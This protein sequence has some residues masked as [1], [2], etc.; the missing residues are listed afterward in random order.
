MEL[1]VPFREFTRFDHPASATIG[2]NRAAFSSRPKAD[3]DLEHHHWNA[4][5]IGSGP[6]LIYSN[7]LQDLAGMPTEFR[8][9]LVMAWDDVVVRYR[10]TLLGPWWMA[11]SH[12]V[13]MCGI[14]LLLGNIFHQS[15]GRYLLYVGLGLT[16][17]SPIISA[18]ADGPTLFLRYKSWILGATYPLS[19]YAVRSLLN[20]LVVM[21]HQIPAILIVWVVFRLPVTPV[22]LLAIVGL[23]P[24]CIFAVGILLVLAPLGARFRDL[25]PAAMA[26]TS[27]LTIMTPIYWDKSGVS[28]TARLVFLFNPAYHMIQLV[29]GSLLGEVP[30]VLNWVVAWSSALVALALGI[31]TMWRTYW[32]I[33][34]SL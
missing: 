16:T 18:V 6:Y 1:A 33:S 27:V 5:V 22:A 10:R 24:M 30:S 20:T 3:K 8:A 28:G 26:A 21:L 14:G 12:L 23:I 13:T 7:A 34:V 29:R 11:I 4:R 19:S 17:F 9:I 2:S 15:P 32:R 25:G 31:F